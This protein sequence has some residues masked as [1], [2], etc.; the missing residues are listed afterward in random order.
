MSP[1]YF[2]ILFKKHNYVDLFKK[3]KFSTLYKTNNNSIIKKSPKCISNNEINILNKLNNSIILN[4]SNNKYV[5]KI[6]YN[7]SDIDNNYLVMDYYKNG[8]LHHNIYT[9]NIVFDKKTY[10]KDFIINLIN[11]ILYIHTMNVVHLDLKLENYLVTEDN[12]F[13]LCDFH[14]SKYHYA[15]YDKQCKLDKVI[16]TKHYI[17]PEIFEYYF[18]KKSDIYSF[19]CI[20]YL[21]YT[22]THYRNTIKYDLLKNTPKE[23]ICLLNDTLRVNPSERPTI[24]DIKNNYNLK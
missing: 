24:Y 19:G 6:N 15:N 3:N 9:K 5:V 21:L 1:K 14:L 18:T 20:L 4:N 8:D 2:N 12:N 11:P 13:I 10:N 17:A 23:V 16:G 22:H 7:Y